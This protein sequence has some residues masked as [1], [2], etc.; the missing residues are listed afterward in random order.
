MPEERD[1]IHVWNAVH[2]LGRRVTSLEQKER[3]TAVNVGQ[4]LTLMSS[5][6]EKIDSLSGKMDEEKK[7]ISSKIDS[8]SQTI[9]AMDKKIV[10]ISVYL[11]IIFGVLWLV[12][13]S[14][15]TNSL[16]DIKIQYVPQQQTSK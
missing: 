4:A 1:T 6:R 10:K 15:T 16:K 7:E 9:S 12:G 13:Q 8:H 11:G 5:L 2:E 14:I 3:E